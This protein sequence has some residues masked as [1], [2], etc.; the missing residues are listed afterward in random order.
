MN[1]LLKRSKSSRDSLRDYKFLREAVITVSKT[2]GLYA[3]LLIL[4]VI[5]GAV[6]NIWPSL[7]LRRIVDGSLVSGSESL[8]KLA[9]LYLG[10]VLL[11]GVVDF[12]REISATVYGQYV[13]LNIRK[14]MLDRLQNLPMKYYLGVPVGETISRFTSDLDAVNTLFSAGLVSALADLLKIISLLGA[15]FILSKPLGLIA[16][17]SLPVIFILSNFFRKRI[18]TR[19]KEVRKRVS[20]INTGI[21]EIYSGMKLIKIFGKENFFAERFEPSLEKHRLAMNANSIYDAWFPCI[22]QMVRA[23][24]IALAIIVG[25]KN[26]MTSFALGLSLGTLAA[27]AD[28][29][30]RLFDPI[31]AVASEIQTIQQAVAGLDRIKQFFHEPLELGTQSN[32][33]NNIFDVVVTGATDSSIVVKDVHFSYPNGKEVIC[34]A[35]MFVSAGSK[36]AIAGRTGSGKTTLMTLIAGLYPTKKG[37]ITIGGHDPFQMPAHTRRRFIGIVPQ[38]VQLF[39]GTIYHNITLRDDS[40]TRE[41]VIRAIET[42]GLGSTIEK[43][44]EGLETLIGEGASQLSFGQTQLLSLARAIVTDPPLLLLDELTSGLDAIT[45]RQVLDAIRN[46]SG[47]RTI[48]T[49]SHRLSGIIDAE[50]VHIMESGSIMESGTPEELTSQEGWY[51]I[52]KRLEERGW[53]VS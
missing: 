24:V 32:D 3:V 21:Q 2:K 16:I 31:E 28:L 10:A 53:R 48:I 12:I 36:V 34:G 5:L 7:M 46:V 20:D 17:G 42:V 49:I 51:S 19:Q 41:Q 23:S 1:R 11:G 26:N 50:V 15:L 45:E 18:Y 47:K 27:A 52:Y 29:F 22:M 35:N 37:T 38:T 8:W 4:A 14:Q 30:I 13:L 43:L 44:P 6:V 9:F 25:A 33:V 40:I 39:N